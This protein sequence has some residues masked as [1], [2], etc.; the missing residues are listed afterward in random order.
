M[1]S[2]DGRDQH[3]GEALD[4]LVLDAQYR[5][6]LTCMRVYGRRGLRVGAVASRLGAGAP[7]FRSRWCSHNAIVSAFASDA[8]RYVDEIIQLVQ[9]HRVP[10]IVPAHDGSIAALRKRR[11]EVEAHT[12]LP[13]GNERALDLAVSKDLTLAL[14]A[15]L[16]IRT[17]RSVIARDLADVR[18]ATRELGV[19]VV[20]KPAESWADGKGAGERF[21][22]SSSLSVADAERCAEPVLALGGRVLVQEWLPGR[23]EAVSLF[24]AYGTCWTKFAQRSFREWPVLGGASVFYESIPLRR[25]LAAPSE[26]LIHAM[27]LD[28]CSVVEFRQDRGGNPVLMEV[29]PRMAGSVSLAVS[30]GVDFPG[31]LRSWALGMP[32]SPATH[33]PVGRRLR[34]LAGDIGSLRNN[35]AHL[36]S[37]DAVSR[38]RAI[39]TF[40]S[41][42][43]TRPSAIDPLDWTDLRPAAI[44]LKDVIYGYSGRGVQRLFR[45]STVPSQ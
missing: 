12:A 4:V 39:A 41:D 26:A 9:E 35:F 22:S 40:L 45:R 11:S 43:V 25:E 36:G 19:P 38:T 21:V 27:D 2:G 7:S 24:R 1:I 34:W 42:F 15:E 30:C 13:I 32:L 29:N 28:G 31:M 5:Q 17:P 18:A 37:P 8:G 16:R 44:E 20:V 3:S 14:A 33:Y 6:S 23:R 10:V